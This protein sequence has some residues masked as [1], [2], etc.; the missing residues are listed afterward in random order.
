M[1]F[2]YLTL[3]ILILAISTSCA[4][5]A[6]DCDNITMTEDTIAAPDDCDNIKMTDDDMV[7][8]ADRTLDYI[9]DHPWKVLADSDSKIRFGVH[10]G[11]PGAKGNLSLY[12]DDSDTPIYNQPV[13]YYKQN[14]NDIMIDGNFINFKDY[15]LNYGNHTALLKYSG[16]E[17]YRPFEESWQFDYDYLFC[18]VP[19]RYPP[20]T[21]ENRTWK[22]KLHIPPQGISGY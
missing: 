15:K 14:S 19:M 6:S 20:H 12:I 22:Y 9:L 11:S 17:T 8:E 21:A 4:V 10:S 5:S 13:R 2:K 16:D 7:G 1:K 3:I 18:R